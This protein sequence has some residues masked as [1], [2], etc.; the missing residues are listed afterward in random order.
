M[1]KV[2]LNGTEETIH[3]R[4]PTFTTESHGYI[5][6]FLDPW[7]K[8]GFKNKTVFDH[9]IMQAVANRSLWEFQS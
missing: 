1:N 8:L 5:W 6:A 4:K 9:L 2:D 3:L 7:L